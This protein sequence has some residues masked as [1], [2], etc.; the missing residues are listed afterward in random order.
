MGF[1]AMVEAIKSQVDTVLGSGGAGYDINH[2][3]APDFTKPQNTV[4]IGCA[5]RT[6]AAF[7]VCIGTKNT[8]RQPGILDLQ[9]FGPIGTNVSDVNDAVE[10]A[11]EAFDYIDI[12]VGDAEGTIV[13]FIAP[14]PTIIGR[15]GGEYQVNVTGPWEADF[16]QS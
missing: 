9:F 5:I 13:K 8:W 3:N 16:Q 10:I 15:N 4:W 11:L 6:A 2:D 12:N 1:S 14:Y 7:T